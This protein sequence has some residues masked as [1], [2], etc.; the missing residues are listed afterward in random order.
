M[1]VPFPFG[2]VTTPK[3]FQKAEFSSAVPFGG[4][5][6]LAKLL[7]FRLYYLSEQP[8]FE[9]SLLGLVEECKV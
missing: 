4:E 5:K 3:A 9:V 1:L 8:H 6:M 7:P 2:T